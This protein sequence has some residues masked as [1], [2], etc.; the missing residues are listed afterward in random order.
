MDEIYLGDSIDAPD[1]TGVQ[2]T[3]NADTAK[4]AATAQRPW[5]P[6]LLKDRYDLDITQ[7]AFSTLR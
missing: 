2:T 3:F 7:S 4:L 1:F 5:F 6:Q